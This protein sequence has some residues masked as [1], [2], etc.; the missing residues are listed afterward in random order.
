MKRIGSMNVLLRLPKVCGTKQTALYEALREAI[1]T[2]AMSL[3]QRLPSTREFSHTFTISR[4]TAVIVYEMLQAEGYLVARRGTGTF[5]APSLPDDRLSMRTE[6][7]Q[8]G[9][10]AETAVHDDRL[11]TPALSL[12]GHKAASLMP[13]SEDGLRRPAPF[14]PYL[15]DLSEFPI[16]LWARL[17][18]KHARLVKPDLLNHGHIA[19]WPPL[20]AAIAAYLRSTRGIG[21]HGDQIILTSSTQQSLSLCACL[22]AE[23]GDHALMESPGNPQAL[24]ILRGADLRV[25]SVPVDAQ[26]VCI[27]A[28][29]PFPGKLRLAYVTPAHQYPTGVVMSVERRQAVLDW[30]VRKK[31]WIF[32]DDD[33]SDFRYSG[34]PLPALYGMC[35]SPCVLHAGSFDKTLFPALCIS[36]LVVPPPLV[37]VFARA[38]S[39]FGRSP[40][41]VS[42]L[43]LCD[44]IESGH[45]VRHIRRMAERYRERR[46]ALIDSLGTHFGTS[47]AISPYP[48]GLGLPIQWKCEKDAS[49]IAEAAAA[50]KLRVLPNSLFQA[51]MPV[52]SGAILGFAAYDLPTLQN[53][54]KRL[55]D[56]IDMRKN[57][58]TQSTAPS[59]LPPS[60]PCG[61]FMRNAPEQVAALRAREGKADCAPLP[62]V[63]G[64]EI[65]SLCEDPGMPT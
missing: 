47:I 58:D 25:V 36:Y 6:R 54:V 19:G 53:A 44:F 48:S 64:G 14:L 52:P 38:Q 24:A 43:V 33:Q 59:I 65:T 20:R 49:T 60:E 30:A 7:A 37:D 8:I 51:E 22:L 1:V 18:A 12:R 34:H 11:S 27:S 29:A 62:V 9:V 35:A 63:L 57:G 21:C 16:T 46:T 32:E 61:G 31:A 28:D 41:I 39:L 40:T 10:A 2:G 50:Q 13:F 56:A 4:G 26:G 17:T 42:Q 15:P 23:R 45:F 55:A 3:N 5:V